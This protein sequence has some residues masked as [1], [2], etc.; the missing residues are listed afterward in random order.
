MI[1]IPRI[2]RV[3]HA[4]KTH[5]ISY[6]FYG[7][8]Q[9]TTAI[10]IGGRVFLILKGSHEEVLNTLDLAGCL[11]YF[12]KH[13]VDA[14]HTSDHRCLTGEHEDTFNIADTLKEVLGEVLFDSFVAELKGAQDEK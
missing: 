11:D 3:T 10:V 12:I 14:G 6:C 5:Y 2:N 4:A 7:E 8:L 9:D 1:P 13:L